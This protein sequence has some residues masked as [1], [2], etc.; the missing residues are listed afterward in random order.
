MIYN[1]N[2]IILNEEYVL[3]DYFNGS[4]I[5][6]IINESFKDPKTKF[7]KTVKAAIDWLINKVKEFG[8]WLVNAPNRLQI[9]TNKKKIKDTLFSVKSNDNNKIISIKLKGEI[10]KY[11][12]SDGYKDANKW[13]NTFNDA[14]EELMTNPNITTDEI[15]A[16]LYNKK[17]EDNWFVNE[18][19]KSLSS[20]NLN[21]DEIVDFSL[22]VSD[23]S[24]PLKQTHNNLLRFNKILEKGERINVETINT[25]NHY[26][27]QAMTSIRNLSY[28]CITVCMNALKGNM[29]DSI[30]Q[31][32]YSIK[33]KKYTHDKE[34][35]QI[36]AVR[37]NP[38]LIL[39]IKDPSEKVLMTAMERDPSLILQIKDQS[40]VESFINKLDEN[41]QIKL[42]KSNIKY[43]YKLK[44][45]SNRV[46]KAAIDKDPYIYESAKVH[47]NEEMTKY[48]YY[49]IFDTER[50]N[51]KL[52]S[53]VWIIR[54]LRYF[55]HEV[56]DEIMIHAVKNEEI[57]SASTILEL[58]A[59]FVNGK[60]D[61]SKISKKVIDEVLDIILNKFIDRKSYKTDRIIAQNLF[62]FAV[63]LNL[64]FH[65]DKYLD[66]IFTILCKNTQSSVTKDELFDLL[67]DDATYKQIEDTLNKFNNF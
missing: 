64:A 44:N 38:S 61:Q 28:A 10:V 58:I 55:D 57:T 47:L 65:D 33:D 42:I 25:I 14:C 39:Q 37:K 31:D 11:I 9:L 21:T 60:P 6:S 34:A 50:K 16:I 45:P 66:K 36:I 63:N 13:I 51:N 8:Q 22:S 17:S 59:P 27:T 35:D 40:I 1:E 2:G 48:C 24:K 4:Y 52:F 32:K 67:K 53:S 41:D 30:E 12:G 18:N 46:T 19:L 3:E 54:Q 15:K 5:N 56:S 23:L 29:S 7:G 43:F 62:S 20:F 26:F 49:T